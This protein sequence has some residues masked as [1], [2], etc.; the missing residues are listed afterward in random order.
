MGCA[1]MYH[2][3][4]MCQGWAKMDLCT[5]YMYLNFDGSACCGCMT[6]LLFASRAECCALK[7]FELG[8]C[9]AGRHYWVRRTAMASTDVPLQLLWVGVP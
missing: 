5:L 3:C 9:S 7:G 6:Q 2:S 8:E 1:Y 4:R